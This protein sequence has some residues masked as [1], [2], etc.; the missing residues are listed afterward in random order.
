M[1]T[2]QIWNLDFA[3]TKL[4]I[5]GKQNIFSSNEKITHEGLLMAKN[6]FE[7]LLYGN[8]TVL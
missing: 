2:S 4:W 8:K 6:S 5:S 3:K 7:G 1:M